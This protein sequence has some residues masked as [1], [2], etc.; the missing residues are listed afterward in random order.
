[1]AREI[2]ELR[3]EENNE[4]QGRNA[5]NDLVNPED[6]GSFGKKL[7]HFWNYYKW[8]V[9]VPLVLLGIIIYSVYAIGADKREYEKHDLV[10]AVVNIVN[11]DEGFEVL[12]EE[13][14]N[15]MDID[16]RG[17][18]RHY[19]STDDIY[20]LDDS[21]ASSIQALSEQI[22]SGLVDVVF[23]NSRCADDHADNNNF[24]DY[25]EILDSDTFERLDEAGLFYYN[26]NGIP[27]GLIVDGTNTEVIGI[28]IP[29]EFT[30]QDEPYMICVN[31]YS[32]RIDAIT[33]YIQ[34]LVAT[35]K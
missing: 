29:A 17:G 10:V 15:S 14:S 32:E 35:L 30:S 19:K 21:V 9:I 6:L 22:R 18:Y 27:T 5:Y 8:Y 31:S 13:Y 16:Y 26:P 7:V 24:E 28:S 4:N 34:T 2:I 3:N 33:A 12:F 20:V 25:R 1:M 23:C 11:P